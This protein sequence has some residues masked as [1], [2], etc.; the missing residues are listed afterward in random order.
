MMSLNK[1][2]VSPVMDYGM[3]SVVYNPSSLWEVSFSAKMKL[4]RHASQGK[5]TNPNISHAKAI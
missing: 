5:K 1:G 4:Q 2:S 3:D